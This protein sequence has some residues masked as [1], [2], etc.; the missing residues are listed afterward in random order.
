[1]ED[2]FSQQSLVKADI[3]LVVDDSGSMAREQCQLQNAFPS[4]FRWLESAK[5]DYRIGITTSD[6]GSQS[7]D[8]GNDG[9]FVANVIVGN[10]QDP[11][12]PN[13]PDPQA[14]FSQAILVGTNG[15]PHD[16]SQEAARLALVR[17]AQLAN[18]AIA[19]NQPVLFLRPDAALLIIFV[20]DGLDY[21]PGDYEYYWR[22]YHQAKGIGNDN[23]ILVSAIA[24]D[25]PSGC[26]VH[27]GT[28]P[29]GCVVTADGH[30]DPG[31]HLYE[32]VTRSAGVFGSICDTQFD[33]TLDQ[34][35]IQAVGL[36][37]RFRLS[38]LPDPTTI[39]VEVHYPCSTDPNVDPHLAACTQVAV[40]CPSGT[41]SSCTASCSPVT[42]SALEVCTASQSDVSGWS[43]EPA[44]QTI[45]FNG[46]A[47]V[48]GLGSVIK[49]SYTLPG[50]Q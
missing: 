24:G 45:V 8:L 34:I 33:Q 13:T 40:Q 38:N 9:N 47:A 43:Y 28:Y 23:L 20:S 44:D 19:A 2:A 35:R 26:Y 18:Q 14:A 12:I 46:T 49:V 10:S 36:Q 3:L 11:G 37:R 21:S 6:L 7:G 50:F 48:P 42:D 31:I 16:Q 39:Q 27:A 25:Y 41:G 4:F 1:M 32:I 29:G 30:I 17:Q 15:S 22:A 5:V